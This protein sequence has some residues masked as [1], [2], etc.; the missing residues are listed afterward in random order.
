MQP[1]ITC[2]QCG[3]ELRIDL[4]SSEAV[5]ENLERYFTG[6]EEAERILKAGIPS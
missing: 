1:S 3:L 2:P 4:D 6:M 5:L